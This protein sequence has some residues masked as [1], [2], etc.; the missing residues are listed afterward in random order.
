MAVSSGSKSIFEGLIT[1]FYFFWLLLSLLLIEVFTES[2][3]Y[4][5]L[6]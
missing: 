5:C 4:Y 2:G 6:A 3:V 1:G